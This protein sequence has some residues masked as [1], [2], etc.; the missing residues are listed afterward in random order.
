MIIR[1]VKMTFQPEQV[2]V[3]QALFEERKAL[4]RQQEGCTHLELWQQKDNACVYF[5]YSIWTAEAF[6]EQYRRSAFFKDTWSKTKLL[7]SEPAQA[8]TVEQNVML[9]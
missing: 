3:F 8:W 5:T 9:P 1:I 6:L 7:F 4:I 2:P